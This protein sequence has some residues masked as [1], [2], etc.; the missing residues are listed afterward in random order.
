M[1]ALSIARVYVHGLSIALVVDK[2]VYVY[3]PTLLGGALGLLDVYTWLDVTLEFY[4]S[5][6]DG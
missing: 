4:V 6:W 5:R 1:A 2:C 3:L